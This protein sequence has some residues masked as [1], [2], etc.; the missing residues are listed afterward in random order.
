ML[1]HTNRTAL[2]HDDDHALVNICKYTIRVTQSYYYASTAAK[3]Q[4]FDQQFDQQL[5]GTC[6]YRWHLRWRLPLAPA[7]GACRWRLPLAPAVG[8]VGTSKVHALH[9]R[10]PRAARADANLG[11]QEPSSRDH[12]GRGHCH[13]AAT[14]VP[15]VQPTNTLKRIYSTT[16]IQCNIYTRNLFSCLSIFPP[17][18]VKVVE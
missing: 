10:L 18:L 11:A 3:V 1:F 8:T 7:V 17:C 15:V 13:A 16:Y 6:W 14:M 9:W 4:Q 12:H 2:Q 5:V